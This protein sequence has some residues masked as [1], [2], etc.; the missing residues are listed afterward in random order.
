MND[1]STEI[2]SVLRWVVRS[3][4]NCYPLK[5]AS[6]STKQN[7]ASA[8]VHVYI[9]TARISFLAFQERA[10]SHNIEHLYMC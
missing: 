3:I 8:A 9:Q 7:S 2:S 5:S 10:V 4:I 6:S 1:I